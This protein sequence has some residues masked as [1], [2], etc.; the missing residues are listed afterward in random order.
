MEYS[1]VAIILIH[2]IYGVNEH[3]EYVKKEL[4][5]LDVAVICP[6]LLPQ[7]NPYTYEQEH[8]AYQ[9]FIQHVGFENAAQQIKQVSRKLRQTYKSVGVVGFSVGATIAW[10]CSQDSTFDFIV[11]CYG[12]R[13]RNY[14]EIEPTCLTLLLFPT[15]E[16][17]FPID[18]LI[19]ALEKKENKNIELKSMQGGHGFM[20]PYDKNYRAESA[21][22]A[23][24]YIEKFIRRQE[25]VE[26]CKRC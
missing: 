8:I 14:T 21:R 3:M 25:G 15:E 11:G 6:N 13:I 7:E 5:K 12:S 24:Q 9:N 19:N 18:T 17:A 10:L 16:T 2:E 20:N 23:F 26:D 4:S 22:K 1:D